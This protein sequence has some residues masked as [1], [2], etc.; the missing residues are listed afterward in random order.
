MVTNDFSCKWSVVSLFVFC[1]SVLRGGGHA[2]E[3]KAIQ[4]M[5]FVRHTV[6]AIQD[7]GGVIEDLGLNYGAVEGSRWRT[8]GG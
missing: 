8:R 6:R 1:G 5:G 4:I 3:K 7:D 2:E